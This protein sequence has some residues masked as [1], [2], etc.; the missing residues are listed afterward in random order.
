MIT[1]DNYLN[2]V[3]ILINEVFGSIWLFIFIGLIA[4]TYICV[5]NGLDTQMTISINVVFVILTCSIYFSS[6]ILA[7]ALLLIGIIIALRYN[8]IINR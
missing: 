4:I 1:P 3:A 7:I 6:L 8:Q 5:I 2:F